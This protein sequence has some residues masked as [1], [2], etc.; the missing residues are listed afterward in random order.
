LAL[1]TSNR[2]QGQRQELVVTIH[3]DGVALIQVNNPPVNALS[4]GVPAGIASAIAA[5]EADASVRAVVLMGAGKT[6]IAGADIKQLEEMAWGK[7]AGV[8]NLHAL[9][10]RIEDCS[11]PV[12]M[13][14]H[15][16]APGGGLELAMAGHYRVAV[17]EAQFGQ[18]EVNLGII[19]SAEGSQRLPRLAGVE[20]ALEMCVS[21]KPVKAPEA[22]AAGIIDN[23]VQG[24]LRTEAIAFARRMA[25]TGLLLRKTR[26]RTAEVKAPGTL[27]E[28]L[29]AA[30]ALAQTT[31]RNLIAPM[32]AV[33]AIESA[34]SLPFDQG[35]ARE[36]QLFQEC[37]ES[38][39]CR[40]LIHAFFAERGVAKV[41]GIGKE[42]PVL[43][44]ERIAIVGAGTMGGGIAMACANAGLPVLLKETRQDALDAG[45]AAIRRNYD[46]SIKRGR[47]TPESVADRVAKIHP[48]LDYSGFDKADLVIEAVFENMALKKQV[49]RELE[50]LIKPDCVLASNTSTLNID[51]LASVANRPENVIGLHF[52]SP[53]NVMRLL[54]IVRGHATKK[55]VL[56]T[57]LAL[58]KRLSK[59]GVVVR[60]CPCFV[61]NRMM[62][63][64]M[65]ETQFLV[66]EGAT[67]QQV[68]AALTR[69]GMAMGMF[70]VDDMAGI[71]VAWR[72]R[73]ELR[74]FSEPG[75]RKP[76]VADKLCDLG[77]FGQK[78]AKGWYLYGQDRKP[79]PDPEVLALIRASA[80]DAGIPQREFSDEEI[81]ER[82]LY[83]LINE[84]A[85]ILEEGYAQRAADIDVIYIN[86]YGFPAWRGGPMFY[87]GTVGLRRIYDRICEFER[88]LGARWKPARLLQRL[89]AENKSFR[90]YDAGHNT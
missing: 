15:G 43:P 24:D 13:A 31:K 22:L 88:D 82:S 42:T 30:R 29:A 16:T 26:D 47:L 68:D 79:M 8:P 19:P 72:I 5:A 20:K 71:D 11:K 45:M 27:Q 64:Y 36:R 18:P 49:F 85:R 3:Q 33:E 65:Y 55:E 86:G 25:E 38:E 52:F 70:E 81:V 37:V 83:G 67:P 51:E 17:Q 41:P 12:V 78:S 44:L 10:Q 66:E 1:N 32:K 90:D 35:C 89:A 56:A 61:G 63:P 59:I 73:Q 76:L 40:A 39:Q 54:E 14:I 57:A 34:A 7:G 75:A 84:G 77:R 28:A 53:A 58:T 48:Q 87:A 6:F 9:L 21:G 4:D 2:S 62:F 23:I 74:H 80:R 46:A 60:N 50:S 69:F